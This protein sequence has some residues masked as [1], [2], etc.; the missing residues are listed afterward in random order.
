MTAFHPS[1]SSLK[2]SIRPQIDLSTQREYSPCSSILR[3][4]KAPLEF[5]A[6]YRDWYFFISWMMYVLRKHLL[7]SLNINK[8]VHLNDFVAV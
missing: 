8:S 2:K 6:F 1:D 5:L 7:G 3:A 4:E